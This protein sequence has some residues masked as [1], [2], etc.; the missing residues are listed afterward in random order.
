MIITPAGKVCIFDPEKQSGIMKHNPGSKLFGEFPPVTVSEWEE[1][2]A[3]DLKGADYE[4]KL[5]WKTIEGIPIKPYYT[6][7][8]TEKLVHLKALPARFP[9]VRGTKEHSNE[10]LVR[11]DIPVTNPRDANTAALDALMKGAGSVGFILDPGTNYSQEDISRLLNNICLASAEINFI[12]AQP[13]EDLLRM[14]DKENISRGGS[15]SDLHGSVEY[16]PLG[17][18]FTTGNYPSG[19]ENAF[20]LAAGLASDAGR[21]PRFSVINVNASVFH[22]AGGSAVQELAFA[23]ASAAAY[24]GRLT[25]AGINAAQA[26]PKIRFT[27]AAGSNYFMEIAKFRAARYLWSRILEA[28]ETGPETAAKTVIHAVT[29]MWN[30]T[31]YDSYVNMLRSTTEAMSAVLGGADSLSVYPFDKAFNDEGTPSSRRIA[32]N[33]QLVMKE[34]ACLDKVAD[35]A[36]GSYYIESL[37][38]SL[39]EEAWKLFLQ[40]DGEGGIE[41]AFF[42]GTVGQMIGE[43]AARRDSY[44]A[45]RRDTLLGT[46]Q[47]PDPEEKVAGKYGSP[48][49]RPQ[50]KTDDRTLAR[51]LK[52][53]RGAHAFE[54]LR[55]RT[56]RHPGGVPEVFLLTYGNLAMR[57]ARAGF[58]SGFFGC[59]GFRVTGNNGFES[60][61]EGAISAIES[62]ASIVVVCSSDEEYPEILP[63]IASTINGKAILVVAGYPKE[64]L[65]MLKE[66]GVKYFIHIRSNVL[67][68]LQQFQQDLGIK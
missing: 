29:S 54:E 58:S 20:G 23:M 55:L 51:P 5:I 8:D 38:S 26:A 40:V 19:E 32:R 2:I 47:Y 46:N 25:A 64:S 37:T 3:K 4:K 53:Y 28:W 11:Q 9:F 36:A 63:E 48:S 16:D 42:N 10:W 43:T 17:T 35:P 67:E 6:A 44:I 39:I 31:V 22:N 24:L 66:A 62:G 41:K 1:L 13:P 7:A 60:P 61:Q 27:F 30:K 12:S 59:A 34:E 14:L 49:F 15:V 52:L 65:E 21:I 56:E 50:H 33:T 18:L 45:M 57:K 68:T